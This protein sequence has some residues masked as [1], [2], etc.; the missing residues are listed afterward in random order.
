LLSKSDSSESASLDV[1]PFW[2]KKDSSS[3]CEM[4]PSP[5]VSSAETTSD[6]ASDARSL[7]SDGGGGGGGGADAVTASA[8]SVSLTEALLS[9]SNDEK[10]DEASLELPPSDVTHELNSSDDMLPSEF[11]SMELNNC[12][13]GSEVDEVE[14][15]DD[16]ELTDDV[17]EL[18]LDDEDVLVEA[19]IC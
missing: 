14:D 8:N 17:L 13:S 12:C 3:D 2:V 18:S 5:S 4:L 7:E 11:V 6:D 1:L 19:D 9:L 16:V 10:S 15:V